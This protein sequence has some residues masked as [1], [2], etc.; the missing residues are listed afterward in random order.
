MR[1]VVT[2]ARGLLGGAI[3][4][5]FVTCHEVSALDRSS[6][7]V[8]DGNAVASVIDRERPDVVINCAA[9]NDV[10]GAE[11]DPVL[12]LRTN[13]FAVLALA[14][15][16]IATGAILI[17]FSSDFVFDGDT[18]RPYVEEDQPNPRSVYAASK[19]LGDLF[20]LETP[21][22]YVLRV[23]SLFGPA[24]PDG[25]RR[26]SLG[27][28]VDGIRR[29]AEVPLFVDRV[30]SPSYTPDLARAARAL[31]ERDVPPGL[32]H[33]VNSGHA[34]WSDIAERAASLMEVELRMR[35]VT[36]ETAGLRARRPRY[37]ALANAKLASV[38]IEMPPWQE[39]LR[40]FLS[41]GS[42]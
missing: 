26:G 22:A 9:Y 18:D 1:V 10:D 3:T 15:V 6:L 33:C 39:A 13:A 2:G 37:C 21:R 4:R 25:G 29:G 32:Y 14:R 20:A 5:E 24:G 34:T 27:T 35:P 36:L 42:G 38:G 41:G 12:A 11:D 17:H 31:L 16:A 40:Q 23:E 7:D 8:T 28:I 19:L 30:V